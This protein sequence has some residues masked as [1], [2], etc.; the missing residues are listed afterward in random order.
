VDALIHILHLEDD[1]LDAELVQNRLAE[2]GLVCRIARVQSQDE[3]EEN[4]RE[5]TLDIILADY[6]LPMY[7]GMSALCLAHERRP[8]L[9]FIFVSGAL[10]E[11]AAIK[12]L[13]QG[14]TDYV[15]KQNLK[16]LVPAVQRALEEAE[17]R[18]HRQRAEQQV[19]LLSFALSGI[20][21]AAFMIDEKARVRYVNE[22]AC[23][24]LE[25]SRD[26]LLT[27]T[28]PDIHSG[29][30][31]KDWPD[32]WRG[33]KECAARTFERNLKTKAGRLVPVE[34]NANF[35]EYGGRGYYLEL[36]RDITERKKA[37]REHLANLEFFES[38]DRVNRAIQGAQNINEMMTAA[39]DEVLSTFTC[40]RVYLLYPCDPEAEAWTVPME[41]TRPEYPG[42]LKMGLVLSM[43]PDVA[44]T[45]RMVLAAERPV[46]FGPGTDHPLP[47]GVAERFGFKCFM[48]MALHPKV[49]QPWQFGL[50]Q[51]AHTR[52]WSP[53]EQ[54]VFQEIGRR[55]ADGLTT[56][57]TFQD[58]QVSEQRYRRIVDTAN[59]GIWMVGED[60]LTSFVN[61]RMA[62]MLGYTE[63]QMV[64]RPVADFMPR[65]DAAHQG[66]WLGGRGLKRAKSFEC[67]FR[68]KDGQTLWGLVSATPL[69][70]EDHGQKGA[71][72]MVTDITAKK[73]AEADLQRLN[74]ELEER[75]VERTQALEASHAELEKAY[76]D[77]KTAHAQMLQQE[78][79]AA[80]GQLAAGVAHE[81]NNPLSYILA[82]LGAIKKYAGELAQ[83]HQGL[84]ASL[85]GLAPES[86][87]NDALAAFTGLRE[88]AEIDF[89][90]EDVQATVAES[91]E[92]ANRMQQIV[93]NLKRF[94][95]LDEAEYK[96]ADLNQGL[97]TTL[98]IVRSEL[99]EKAKVTRSYGDLP[100]IVCN[101]GQ[102]NQVF[103]NL[104]VNA[105]QAI[106]GRGEIEIATHAADDTIVIAV[107][108]TGCGIPADHLD[109][110]FEPFFTTKEVGKGTGLGLSIAY[111]IVAK[112]GGEIKVESPPG[113][114]TRFTIRLPIR[115]E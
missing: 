34:I 100:Q 10:G 9:P 97:E 11:E 31:L 80:I 74:Q 57:L 39:L 113:Q 88:R 83:F 25:Y 51:C 32:H 89:I 43:T 65:E 111:D 8:D 86:C 26:H 41:R 20:H 104:L 108:D 54:R 62:R 27:M 70:G 85:R 99:K 71:F 76:G 84:S 102:L 2:A 22:E 45:A 55:L 53:E 42:V 75:V 92:G 6:Q 17:N 69:P 24:L 109:R 52:I 61:A 73:L 91:L 98:D 107:A 95:R 18:R 72:A 59:E 38:M 30:S 1:P 21:E 67:R 7:D 13:T 56:W 28:L 3:Y 110:I 36:L 37:E 114:G 16:R 87:A 63:A 77:L 12:A 35:F 103:L 4:L 23:R 101:P 19:A 47:P 48:A 115:R 58:L 112:H 64:G 81:I 50:H 106:E 49:G 66:Q 15:L 79:M 46:Q 82:N 33:L 96:L 44:A 90:L 78:K 60:S 29:F 68:C 14:A 5:D 105:A 94:A 40:D 93:E